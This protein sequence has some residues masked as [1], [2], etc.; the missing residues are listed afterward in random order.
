M[1]TDSDLPAWRSDYEKMREEM[2]FG[3]SPTFAQLLDQIRE[4]EGRLNSAGR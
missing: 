2:F 4:L 1:P 3:D